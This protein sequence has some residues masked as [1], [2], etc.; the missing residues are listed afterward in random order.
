MEHVQ[1]CCHDRRSIYDRPEIQDALASSADLTLPPVECGICKKRTQLPSPTAAGSHSHC[2][3]L[4]PSIPVS[5]VLLRAWSSLVDSHCHQF[6]MLL[7]LLTKAPGLGVILLMG[8]LQRNIQ[9]DIW[10]L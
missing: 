2:P 1:V 9:E 10:I 7:N 4:S 5:P 3:T 8:A 6:P